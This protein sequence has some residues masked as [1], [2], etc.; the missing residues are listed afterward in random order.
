MKEIV[1]NGI[2]KDS[3]RAALNVIE[4][5]YREADFGSYPKGIFYLIDSF[6]SWLYDE[7][8]PFTHLKAADTFE[9]LKKMVD[10]DYYEKLIEEYFINDLS[11]Y[12][13]Y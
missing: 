12:S 2:D 9:Y 13:F 6:E 1:E 5:N 7:M 4:F 3:L 8:E 10:T 11:I